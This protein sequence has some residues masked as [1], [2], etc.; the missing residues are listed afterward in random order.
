MADTA[1]P[2]HYQVTAIPDG[3]KTFPF[4]SCRFVNLT[5]VVL[6]ATYGNEKV[7]VPPKG[8]AMT[9]PTPESQRRKPSPFCLCKH[10]HAAGT[11]TAIQQHPGRAPQPPVAGVHY[12][13]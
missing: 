7:E 3:P 12:P 10:G 5:A 4:P 11:A 6:N 13:A 8:M 9:Y 2:N 1:A